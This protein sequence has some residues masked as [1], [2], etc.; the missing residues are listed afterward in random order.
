MK[1]IGLIS[2]LLASTLLANINGVG[3]GDTQ[4]LAKKEAL[5]DLSRNIKSEVRSNFEEKIEVVGDDS[6]EKTKIISNTKVSSNLPILGVEFQEI[7]VDDGAKVEASLS[8]VKVT[9]LYVNKLNNLQK[10]INANLLEVKRA[11]SNVIKLKLYEKLYSLLNDYDRYESVAVILD[12][13]LPKRVNIT[14]A[15]VQS[16]MLKLSSDIDSL[17]LAVNILAKEFNK[18]A[19]F[20]YPPLLQNHTTVAKFGSVFMQKLKGKIDA[21]YKLKN[22]SYKLIGSYTLGK[23]SM[24]LNYTLIDIKSNKTIKSKTITLPKKLYKN[25]E[26]KPKGVDFA[27]L[28]HNGVM[29]SHNLKVDLNTNKGSENLLFKDGEEIEL[30]VKL[31]KMSY[32]YV[33]GYTQTADGKLSYLLDLT[34]GAGDSKFVKFVNADD[35]SKWISLGAFNVAPP[36]GVESLQVIASNKKPTSLP[37]AKYDE[38]SGYYI[39]SN[40][41]K[42]ALF[43][44]RGIKRKKSSKVE[45]S[46]DVINFT[47]MK[48]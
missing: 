16:E 40:N 32:F 35:A 3:V 48:R 6:D 24:I 31:N 8:P 9:K 19:I 4:S 14:K 36:F 15:K 10:E 38:A 34:D 47:T 37:N 27:S 30:F 21:S 20:V 22:A 46:E 41:I 23:K 44:T 5:G 25:L 7:S 1:K 11:S 2:V 18:K 43:E 17:D 33:V 13:K 29:L 12:A 26:V 45:I 39:I 42:K 28:L